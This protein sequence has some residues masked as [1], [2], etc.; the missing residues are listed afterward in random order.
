MTSHSAHSPEMK[1]NLVEIYRQALASN[2]SISTLDE[3]VEKMWK[4]STVTSQV[5]DASGEEYQQKLRSTIPWLVRYGA[6]LLPI[7]FISMGLFLLGSAL[8]PIGSFYL[9]NH[10]EAQ[11]QQLAAPI[12]DHD[13]LELSPVIV[14]QISNQV[15]G[16]SDDLGNSG[17]TIIDTQ[18]DYTN[19]ANWFGDAGLPQLDGSLLDGE[20][21]YVI[22]IPSLEIEEAHVKIGGTDLNGSLIQYPG[23]AEPGD[24]GAP[25]IFGHSVLPQFYNPSQKNP[26]RYVSIF[27]K[28]MSL[29]TGDDI[30]VTKD[31]VKYHYRVRE[32]DEV[33][34]EDVYIL[35]QNYDH[36]DL[37]LVTCTP[38]GTYLRRGVVVAELVSN[39]SN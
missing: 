7:G 1:K 39:G 23:T 3:K 33:D 24:A 32:K 13:I 15:A 31:N 9:Q 17:P 25:V 26:R 10:I 2:N 20:K 21:E 14:S 38:P 30:F 35:T 4:R 29:K 18:L 8:I 19:L 27:T 16:A 22:E 34:P 12:P 37:K 11:A 28:I 5:E 36:K 6:L